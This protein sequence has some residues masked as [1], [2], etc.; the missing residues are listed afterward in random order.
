MQIENPVYRKTNIELDL[1]EISDK[2]PRNAF[3]NQR[4][5]VS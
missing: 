3:L 5:I 1:K 2:T 4:K